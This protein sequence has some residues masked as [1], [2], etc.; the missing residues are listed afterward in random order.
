MNPIAL[1]CALITSLLVTSGAPRP[2]TRMVSVNGVSLWVDSRGA[3]AATPLMV[4][5]GGPGVSHEYMLVS[6]VWDSLA[7]RRQVIFYDQRGTGRSPALRK[8]QSCTLADQIADLEALRVRLGLAQMDVLGHSWGGSLAMAYAARHPRH[9]RRMI[10][11]DSAAPKWEE[12]RFLFRDIFPEGT[13]RQDALQ[14]AEQQGDT[15]ALHADFREY[16]GMLA[17]D[18]KLREAMRNGPPPAFSAAVNSALF[19]EMKNVDLGPEI[20]K[21]TFPTLVLCGRFDANVAPSVAWKIH[22]GIPGSEF[23]VFERSGHLPF[24]EE[25][26]AFLERVERFLT[27]S[28]DARAN[29]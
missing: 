13:E 28:A 20:A 7:T 9:I 21:F 18:P 14:F 10:L 19:A 25:S 3:G 8:D 27:G 12:T 15:A 29:R 24:Y 26:D 4:L 11:C 6:S 5:N 1:G 2:S 16:Q 17:C 23:T 22:H